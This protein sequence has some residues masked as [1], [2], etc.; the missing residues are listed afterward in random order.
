[1]SLFIRIDDD[2]TVFVG[3]SNGPLFERVPTRGTHEFALMKWEK[4]GDE[5]NYKAL[6]EEEKRCRGVLAEQYVRL[7]SKLDDITNVITSA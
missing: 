4:C 2:K 6:Y 5:P 3:T 7:Q 1:M